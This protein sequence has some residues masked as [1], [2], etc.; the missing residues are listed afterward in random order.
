M[1]ITFLKPAPAVELSGRQVWPVYNEVFHD[2]PDEST[3]L[4][5][6][7][8]K[9]ARRGGFV[10]WLAHQDGAAVGF[11]WGYL[12]QPGQLWSDALKDSLDTDTY[13][14]WVGGH[15]EIVSLGVSPRA[16]RHGVARGLLHHLYASTTAERLLLQ[17][18][19]DA[20]DGARI[21]YA[22]EG[23]Q[24]LGPGV[25]ECTVVMGRL[26]APRPTGDE[27]R[28]LSPRWVD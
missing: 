24:V 27:A 23:W 11:A 15:F 2:Q 6:T 28:A 16:R 5:Q 8:E 7:W 9:H 26:L 13:A 10:C 20:S 18:T 4:E 21:L 25:V 3:W 12:G 17:T 14:R 22:D 19:D 1:T